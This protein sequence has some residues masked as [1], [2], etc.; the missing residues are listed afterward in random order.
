MKGYCFGLALIL[1]PA[2]AFS[3]DLTPEEQH[4]EDLIKAPQE[5]MLRGSFLQ[6]AIANYQGD[7]PIERA[8]QLAAEAAQDKRLH[9]DKAIRWANSVIDSVYA[10]PQAKYAN[11]NFNFNEFVTYCGKHYEKYGRENAIS[12]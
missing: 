12:R 4:N 1:L 5:C 3:A 9:A 11:V 6:T 10:D 2:F 8:K 7:V